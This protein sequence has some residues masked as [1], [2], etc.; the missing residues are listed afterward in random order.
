MIKII[1]WVSI[2]LVLYT[3]FIYPLI[4]MLLR[5]LKSR[6]TVEEK[7]FYPSVSLIISAYNEEKVLEAKIINCLQLSYP[8]DRLEIIIGSD[9]STD[10]TET[11]ANKYIEQGVRFLDFSRRTGKVNVL[12]NIIPQAK[13]GIIVLSDANTIYEPNSIQE[14]VKH[15][16]NPRIGCVCGKLILKKPD[17]S[18]GGEFEGIYWKYES[19]LKR[20]E[21][22]MGFL[23]GA[24]GGI[25]AIRKNLFEIIPT[26]TIV[27]DF[28]IP[29]KILENGYKIIYEPEA[30]AFEETSKSIAE[31]IKRK[32]RIGAGAYQAILLT[33][34]MLN[35]FRGFPSFAYWSHKVIRWFVP[36]LLIFL[37]LFNIL[38]IKESRYLYL[39]ILQCIGYLGAFTGYLL[40]KNKIQLKLFT[41]LYYFVAMNVALLIGF[42]RFIMGLQSV[43]WERVD[44]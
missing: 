15:F 34:P 31:E 27:E 19:F 10:R 32:I 39:F 12:N 7:D 16:I 20:L 43:T 18:Y 35:I 14:L 25:Y 3:Y 6:I 26:N 4:L 33:I 44:R 38:L 41:P 40:N 30:V 9:G 1:F 2:S 22:R 28:V 13:G 37:L 17:T 36:F 42:F 29:M 24:N 8:K 11:I 23:L 5:L 21:G